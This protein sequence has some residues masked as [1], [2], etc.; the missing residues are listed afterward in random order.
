MDCAIY[1][2]YR[3][4]RAWIS[5]FVHAHAALTPDHNELDPPHVKTRVM[6]AMIVLPT[7]AT[8]LS[9]HPN[10]HSLL[11]AGLTVFIQFSTARDGFVQ[12]TRRSN[13][14]RHSL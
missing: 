13:L 7:W 1:T 8:A 11:G 12:L 2:H 10:L 4:L 5:L 3:Y 14:F 6:A 9:Y